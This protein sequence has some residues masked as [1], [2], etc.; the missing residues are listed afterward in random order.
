M[1]QTVIV[2][3]TT[4][5]EDTGPLFDLYS[6]DGEYLVTGPF[7]TN[8]HKSGLTIGFTTT[9]VPD[10]CVSIRVLSKGNCS[11][12][13]DITLPTFTPTVTPTVTPTPAGTSTPT[14][15]PTSTSTPTPTVTPIAI[16]LC[17]SPFDLT[18]TDLCTCFGGG[19]GGS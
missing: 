18:G 2:T 3:L 5:G 1:A 16:Q 9:N 4:I 6:I 17:Y 19:A 8:I 13:I 10:N 14:P 12:F 15:T 11:N 7:E